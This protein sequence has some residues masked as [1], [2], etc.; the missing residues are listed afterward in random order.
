M[1]LETITVKLQAGF[2]D[3]HVEDYSAAN[4]VPMKAIIDVATNKPYPPGIGPGV[5]YLPAAGL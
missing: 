3:G 1:N 2:T 5:Y 4:V